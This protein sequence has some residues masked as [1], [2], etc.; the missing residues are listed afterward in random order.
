MK[1]KK[2]ECETKLKTNPKRTP[3]ECLMHALHPSFELF[4]RAPWSAVAPATAFAGIS[5]RQ[6]RCRTPKRF[7]HFQKSGNEA[8]KYLKTKEVTIA[9]AANCAR[10][11]RPLAA[12]RVQK[13]PRTPHFARTKP[14]IASPEA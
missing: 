1:T 8:K 12:I 4:D 7:A 9:N 3:I 11:A 6:L 5:R 13:E 14:G 10:L 2:A